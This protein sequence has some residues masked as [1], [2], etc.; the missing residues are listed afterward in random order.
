ML[1]IA[2]QC[3]HESVVGALLGDIRFDVNAKSMV[4]VVFTR[5]YRWWVLFVTDS[6]RPL[7]LLW[8]FVGRGT[9]CSFYVLLIVF[10]QEDGATPL[11]V[12]ARNGFAAVV[13]LLLADPRVDVN[14]MDAVSPSAF[15]SVEPLATQCQL[16][17]RRAATRRVPLLGI[18]VSLLRLLPQRGPR[19]AHCSDGGGSSVQSSMLKGPTT[20]DAR[21]GP[22]RGHRSLSPLQLG[23][24]LR[25]LLPLRRALHN[26]ALPLLRRLEGPLV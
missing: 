12:A 19:S 18:P 26:P 6:V 1:H 3:G 10:A 23:L 11:H 22:G 15:A 8:S 25:L 2:A 7:H 21:T 13:A 16:A 20:S 9:L 4:G 24:R 5:G 17:E 14:I